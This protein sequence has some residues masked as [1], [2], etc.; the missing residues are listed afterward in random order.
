MPTIGTCM[1][2][3]DAGV[4]AVR[5]ALCN[6]S[7]RSLA[8]RRVASYGHHRRMPFR[9][10]GFCGTSTIDRNYCGSPRLIAGAF[11]LLSSIEKAQADSLAR[12][13]QLDPV[14]INYLERAVLDVSPCGDAT[15]A[16][17]LAPL[18]NSI[19]EATHLVGFSR[20]A[21]CPIDSHASSS[22]GM[23]RRVSRRFACDGTLRCR[24]SVR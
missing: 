4:N 22:F 21:A 9:H 12:R 3:V 1:V 10:S 13:D 14:V 18:G 16:R 6:M 8:A 17:H 19:A 11:L 24:K 20:A 23:F 2:N 5:E 7:Q 15:G